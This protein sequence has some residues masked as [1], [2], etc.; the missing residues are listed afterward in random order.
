MKKSLSAIIFVLLCTTASYSAN[1]ATENWDTPWGVNWT[2]TFDSTGVQCVETIGYPYI[3]VAVDETTDGATYD[4]EGAMDSSPNE[5]GESADLPGS[6]N[7]TADEHFNGN[8]G[9]PY[10][11]VRLD[12]CSSCAVT[13]TVQATTTGR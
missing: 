9:M 5:T 4:I 7:L 12:S 8:I 13:A 11:C 1:T 3:Y 2:L 6:S 10:V